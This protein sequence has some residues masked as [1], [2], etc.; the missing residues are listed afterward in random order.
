MIGLR[1]LVRLAAEHPEDLDHPVA[2]FRVGDRVLDTDARPA[3]MGVVNLSQDSWYRE[4]IA[5]SAEAAVRRGIVLAAQGA[6][7]VDVG[8]ES[9]VAGSARVGP[10]DQIRALVPVVEELA[11]AGVAV[12]VESYHPDVVRATLAAG[13]KVLNLTGSADDDAMFELAA[14]FDAALVICHVLGTNPRELADTEVE[15][16]PYPAMVEALGA[17]AEAARAHGVRAG[18]CVD[19]GA[20]FGMARLTDPLD[21]VR[22]QSVLLLHS[23]RLRSLGLPVCHA[24]PSGFTYFEDEVRTAEGFFAVLAGLGGTGVHRTHEVPRV[25]AVL[26]AMADLPVG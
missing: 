19:P 6:D 26:R 20:G 16:D 13:A 12:S 23:F 4:S 24:L 7:V 22:H 11:A 14:E 8:A 21:R 10:Q 18:I 9:V 5:P 1:E 17:R 15:R 2:P 25:R 3:I